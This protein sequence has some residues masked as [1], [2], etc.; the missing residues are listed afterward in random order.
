MVVEADPLESKAEVRSATLWQRLGNGAIDLYLLLMALGMMMGIDWARPYVERYGLPIL[1]FAYYI[2]FEMVLQRTP[3]KFV[4]GTLVIG[5]D[6]SKPSVSQ[7]A[8]RAYTRFVPWDF[9]TAFRKDRFMLHDQK[10]FTHVVAA[11][12]PGKLKLRTRIV[13]WSFGLLFGF[14]AL[15]LFGVSRTACL[16][17]LATSVL[18]FS[19]LDRRAWGWKALVVLMAMLIVTAVT[20]VLIAPGL[21]FA[22]D[23]P[24][25]LVT[26]LVVAALPLCILLT[27]APERWK[28]ADVDPDDVYARLTRA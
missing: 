16:L 24:V 23:I 14:L 1:W 9:L 12:R 22:P 6:G 11:N 5:L 25:L 19:L 4:T 20:W 7:I 26:T 17:L 3:G 27:D 13:A 15:G 28:A 2:A 8:K 18:W 21:G 10:S